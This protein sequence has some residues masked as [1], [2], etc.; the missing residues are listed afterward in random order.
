MGWVQLA[1]RFKAQQL[2][3]P[4]FNIIAPLCNIRPF[5]VGGG[6]GNLGSGGTEG[7]LALVVVICLVSRIPFAGVFRSG[8]AAA[9]GFRSG[10]GVGGVGVGVRVCI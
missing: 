7:Q 1:M 2:P 8:S 9:A 10:S 4:Y 6:I 5:F 3:Q